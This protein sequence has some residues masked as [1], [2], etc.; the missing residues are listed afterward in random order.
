MT[1]HLMAIFTI[2]TDQLPDNFQ[3]IIKHEQAAVAQWKEAGI[4]THL[5]LRPTRNGAVLIFN[6]IDEPKA[7]EL[8]ASLPLYPFMQSVEYLPLMK[9]F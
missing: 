8:M 7:R 2:N 6:D 1:N 9:Q 5:F 3:E 4:L